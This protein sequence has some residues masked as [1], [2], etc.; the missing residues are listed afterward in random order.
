MA[1]DL[2]ERK[3]KRYVAQLDSLIDKNLDEI[4]KLYEKFNSLTSIVQQAGKIPLSLKQDCTKIT[5]KKRL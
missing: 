3:I 5:I 1:N 2:K 4:E